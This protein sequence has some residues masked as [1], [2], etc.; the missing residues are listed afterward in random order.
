MRMGLVCEMREGW[1]VGAAVIK[2]MAVEGRSVQPRRLFL[3]TLALTL[4]EMKLLSGYEKHVI[5]LYFFMESLVA[6]LTTDCGR[7]KSKG[8]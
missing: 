3:R 1:S 7:N 5:L 6:M 2:A 4:R 8:S